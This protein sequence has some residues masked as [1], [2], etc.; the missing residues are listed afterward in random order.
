MT[1]KNNS[2]EKE[3]ITILVSDATK[4][5][6]QDFSKTKKYSTLSKLIRESVEFFIDFSSKPNPITTI[7]KLSH[8]LKEP[9][10]A[11]KGFSHLLI[12]N[13]KDRLDWGTLTKIKQVYDQSIILEDIIKGVLDD[14][15]YDKVQY[16]ILIVDDDS[17]T[18]NVLLDFFQLKGYSCKDFTLGLEIFK[19]LEIIKPKIILLDILLPDLNGYEICKKIKSDEIFNDILV[20]YISA[21]PESEIM[22][23]MEETMADGYFLKP[24]NFLEFEK[25]FN[26]L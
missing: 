6:W 9:L 14:Y 13:Y 24:F 16:D 26:F 25:L 3:R 23:H 19:E 8:D 17:S 22:Q 11:I 20:F 15:Q 10:T 1:K 4:N 7:S 21:V 5:R 12:E 18:N 2:K